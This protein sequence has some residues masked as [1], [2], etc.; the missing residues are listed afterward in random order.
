MPKYKG[1]KGTK[2]R[3]TLAEEK[4]LEVMLNPEH[5]LKTVTVICDIAKINRKIFY[6][7]FE[8][9]GFCEIYDKESKALVRKAKAPIINACI[10]QAVR[11]DA[12]H[13]KML[14]SMDGIYAGDKHLYP[15]EDGKPQPVAPVIKVFTP[16]EKAARIAYIL[17][18]G[19]ELKK[20]AEEEKGKNGPANEKY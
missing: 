11:G 12:T 1:Q 18:K 3:P 7:A 17:Q 14:L 5:R 20:K 16:L 8:K 9:P 13:A 4:L 10:R 15:G 6:R 2:Y 19:L